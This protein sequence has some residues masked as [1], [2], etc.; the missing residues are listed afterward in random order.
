M[1]DATEQQIADVATKINELRGDL[2]DNYDRTLKISVAH[3][4]SVHP[5]DVYDPADVA[6]TAGLVRA[7]HTQV[8][9][10]D[11]QWYGTITKGTSSLKI[12]QAQAP[13]EALD[14]A[15][16]VLGG[17]RA[18]IEVSPAERITAPYWMVSGPLTAGVKQRIDRQLS[19]MPGPASWVGVKDGFITQLTMGIPSEA[20]A[21]A[22][23][24]AAIKAVEGGPQ[25]P[26]I[27][28]WALT[29]DPAIR[30][31]PRWAGMALI[32]TC[33]YHANDTTATA[34]LAPHAQLLQQRIRREFDTCPK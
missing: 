22:D 24:V 3:W 26:V 27:L 32:G 19:A 23:L 7:L 10:Q 4:A 16:R 21:Y 29:D 14:A 6:R 12:Y 30:D 28:R 18:D 1:E 9:A 25:H 15:L 33:G 17:R 8:Q 31:E 5:G 13:G 34:N 2:F 20:T 11:I